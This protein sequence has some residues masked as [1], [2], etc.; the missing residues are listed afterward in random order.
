MRPEMRTKRVSVT[1]GAG[2]LVSVINGEGADEVTY[3]QTWDGEDRHMSYTDASG[4]ETRLT[5]DRSGRLLQETN[6]ARR[7]NGVYV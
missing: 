7:T 2:R 3:R 6:A 5:Y 4:N 1:D